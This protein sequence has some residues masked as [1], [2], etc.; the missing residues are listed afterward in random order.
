MEA[1]VATKTTSKAMSIVSGLV[2]T[3]VPVVLGIMVYNLFLTNTIA[4]LKAKMKLA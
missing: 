2:V 1:N 3:A 4:K